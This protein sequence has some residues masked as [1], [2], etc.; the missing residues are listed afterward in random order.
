M[1]KLVFAFAAV[2]GLLSVALGAF[3]AHGLRGQLEDKLMNAFETG[4][5]YQMQH[6]LALLAVGICLS[7]WGRNGLL[8]SAGGFFMAGILLFSG[9]LYLLALTGWRWPGPITPLGG[10][11]LIIGWGLLAAGVWQ[12]ARPL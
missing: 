3:A 8:V 9:S 4:V 12:H 10:V 11:C 7:I 2:S 1:L 6:S 5:T